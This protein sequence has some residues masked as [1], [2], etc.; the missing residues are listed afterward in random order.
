MQMKFAGE[1]STFPLVAHWGLYQ[2]GIKLNDSF[3]TVFEMAMHVSFLLVHQSGETHYSIAM[4]YHC[5][6]PWVAGHRPSVC[7]PRAYVDYHSKERGILHYSSANCFFWFSRVLFRFLWIVYN[8]I[9]PLFS[10][11]NLCTRFKHQ[12]CTRFALLKE[13]ILHS[14]YFHKQFK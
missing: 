13:W 14:F 3:P 6:L 5:S 1:S 9:S 8:E 12:N 4:K 7:G 2:K 11:L 10:S